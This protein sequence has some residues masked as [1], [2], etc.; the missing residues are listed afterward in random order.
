MPIYAELLEPAIVGSIPTEGLDPPLV[1]AAEIELSVAISLKRIADSLDRLAA[2]VTPGFFKPNDE[3]YPF[4]PGDPSYRIWN[5]P[6]RDS[7][8]GRIH[9]PRG[10]TAPKTDDTYARNVEAMRAAVPGGTDWSAPPT[11]EEYTNDNPWI[12]WHGG[13][14]PVTDRTPIDVKLR[15]GHE[16]HAVGVE[17]DWRWT[18]SAV[19]DWMN[20]PYDI[21]AWRISK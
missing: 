15:N 18:H 14:C 3:P 9:V 7:D 13:E 6:A 2:N 8:P 17:N 20:L 5:D 1:M 12:E 4:K 16:T 10:T 19:N 11:G 21:V